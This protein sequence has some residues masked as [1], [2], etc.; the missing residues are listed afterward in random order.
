MRRDLSGDRGETVRARSVSRLSD[1]DSALPDL[2]LDPE[3]VNIMAEKLRI[4]VDENIDTVKSQS[5]DKVVISAGDDKVDTSVVARREVALQQV[6][7]RKQMLQDS[8]AWIQN[9]LMTVVG[10]G[11]LAYLQTLESSM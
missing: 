2:E 6:D 5:V 3:V 10:V 1:P 4:E 8:K 9:S 7:D 11:V